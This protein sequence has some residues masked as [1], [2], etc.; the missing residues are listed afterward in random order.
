MPNTESSNRINASASHGAPGRTDG[1]LVPTQDRASSQSRPTGLSA[2]VGATAGPDANRGAAEEFQVQVD[3]VLGPRESGSRLDQALAAR[4]PEFSRG[5]IRGWIEAGMVRVDGAT[6]R[7]RDRMQ[8][9]ERIAVRAAIEPVGRCEPEPVPLRV[10]FEDEHLL[11]IDK[12]AGLVVHPAAGNWHGTL[13][14]GL[15]Y[16]DPTLDRLPRSGIVH[17][18]DKDTSGLLVVAR[19]PLAHKSLTEQLQARTVSR[20]YRA[21]VVGEL[22]GSGRVDAPIGRHPTRRTSMA[23]VP[24]GRPSVTD[25]QVLAN[26]PGHS[27]LAVQLHTGRTHQIRVHMAHI[28]HPLVGDP[29]YGGRHK[30]AQP[31]SRALSDIAL[32]ALRCFPRQAL[33]AIRLSLIHPE[34]GRAMSWELPMADD[35]T[36]LIAALEAG[37]GD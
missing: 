2:S 14:N 33:H 21:V 7:A 34:Q 3:L 4:L 24:T 32:Q 13:Q 1:D 12:P 25:Y 19:T 37:R 31:A 15:L 30:G 23:V 8:G 29:V 10:L 28:Q 20:E 18:L 11:V 9:G 17:R 27:L 36:Y 6:R 35:L 26:Y 16:R 22:C 5:C